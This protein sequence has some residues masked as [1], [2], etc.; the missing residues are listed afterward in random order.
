MQ[1]MLCTHACLI[2]AANTL[3]QCPL[4][5]ELSRS[6]QDAQER[7]A[8]STV[9]PRAKHCCMWEQY[10]SHQ[11]QDNDFQHDRTSFTSFNQI[12][13]HRDKNENMR[14]IVVGWEPLQ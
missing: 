11:D 1:G 2:A 3:H 5:I 4:N 12:Q 14:M 9:Q 13:A 10:Q 6:N 7:V 8:G